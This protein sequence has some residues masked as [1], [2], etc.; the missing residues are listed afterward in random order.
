M[1]PLGGLGSQTVRCGN[2]ATLTRIHDSQDSK[3]LHVVLLQKKQKGCRV[4]R[5]MDSDFSFLRARR[6]CGEPSALQ[7][8]NFP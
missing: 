6:N 4:V 1:D 5:A 3:T 2:V 7:I 8:P